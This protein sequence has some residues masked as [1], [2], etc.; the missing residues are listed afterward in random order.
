MMTSAAKALQIANGNKD[1]AAFLIAYVNFCHLLD[2]VCD[3]D[4]PTPDH[5]LAKDSEDLIGACLL[6]PFVRQHAVVLWPLIVVGFNAWLDSNAM[7]ASNEIEK[8]VDADVVK[9]IYQEILWFVADLCGGRDHRRAMSSQHREYNHD[10]TP[11]P[12]GGIK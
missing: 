12:A 9:S 11:K 4:V 5:R 8:Q 10:F 7:Q 1:A 2:D 6:N 3:A